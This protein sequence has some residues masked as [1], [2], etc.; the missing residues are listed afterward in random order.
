M[1]I[2]Y[3]AGLVRPCF[4]LLGRGAWLWELSTGR[5]LPVPCLGCLGLG[6]TVMQQVSRVVRAAAHAPLRHAGDR[7]VHY[8]SFTA[9]DKGGSEGPCCLGVA[10]SVC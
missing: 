6:L 9:K 10:P 8:G 2:H 4:V 3:C 7:G 1:S 5:E